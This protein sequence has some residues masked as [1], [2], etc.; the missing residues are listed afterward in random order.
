MCKCCPTD[1]FPQRLLKQ[2]GSE[3]V[4]S[5]SLARQGLVSDSFKEYAKTDSKD[6]LFTSTVSSNEQRSKRRSAVKSHSWTSWIWTWIQEF[7]RPNLYCSR[8]SLKN[9]KQAAIFF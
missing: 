7:T 1:R 3:P 6:L 2:K 4:S 8:R 9:K 5:L